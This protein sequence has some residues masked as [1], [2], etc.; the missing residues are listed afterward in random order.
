MATRNASSSANTPL[1][2]CPGCHS[3]FKAPLLLPCCHTVCLECVEVTNGGMS[4]CP[5][6]QSETERQ[7]A[8]LP[9]DVITERVV[10]VE[11]VR[12]ALEEKCSVLCAECEEDVSSAEYFCLVCTKPICELDFKLHKRMYKD[13]HQVISI[14]EVKLKS[15][16][17]LYPLQDSFKCTFHSDTVATKFCKTCHVFLCAFCLSHHHPDHPTI[18]GEDVRQEVS[19]ISQLNRNKFEG[20]DNEDYSSTDNLIKKI[21][22]LRV[23][24]EAKFDDIKRVLEERREKIIGK[25]DFLYKD[26]LKLIQK[27]QRRREHVRDLIKKSRA[28]EH[29]PMDGNLLINL[30]SINC[31]VIELLRQPHSRSKYR[32]IEFLMNQ[33][34]KCLL[35]ALGCIK[36]EHTH[37]IMSD[38]IIDTR[39]SQS[40]HEFTPCFIA[41]GDNDLLYNLTSLCEVVV[42]D[43]LGTVVRS[44]QLPHLKNTS[45]NFG[46]IHWNE[47]LLYIVV[48]KK[49][50]VTV[51][52]EKGLSVKMFGSKGAAQGQFNTP[53][54]IA[55]SNRNGDIYVLENGNNR[56]QVLNSQYNSRRFIGNATRTP[57][58][59]RNPMELA[60]TPGNEVV[61]AHKY[62]PCI[63]MYN[64][65]GT[66]LKQFGDSSLQG[67]LCEISNMSIAHMGQVILSDRG[68]KR[69]IVYDTDLTT[70]WTVG[71]R[72]TGRGEYSDPLGSACLNDG[73]VYV[74]DG[75]NRRILVYQR[76]SLFLGCN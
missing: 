67:Y 37:D 66:L 18:S 59:L 42:M 8:S 76:N 46:F 47:G 32:D 12:R 65:Y 35:K 9:R 41:K 69:M 63:N 40:Y 24:V 39:A 26:T 4:R 70:M 1:T 71:H 7:P 60:L 38:Y 53:T 19:Q 28:Y 25:L 29:L 51:C 17:Q 56:V 5:K 31:K 48:G 64:S 27:G 2:I 73:T 36:L 58:E 52:T 68:Q 43:R 74:C 72:G 30:D 21:S 62:N 15:L 16:E 6:C 50:S 14:E 75:G 11:S 45:I 49:H 54:S 44:F 20:L 55:V 13:T 34:V 23:D 57:G 3:A 22:S 61:V 33:D 10:S